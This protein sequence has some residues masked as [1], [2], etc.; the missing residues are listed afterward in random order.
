MKA[1][2]TLAATLF[3]AGLLMIAA[4]AGAGAADFET[5]IACGTSGNALPAHSCPQRRKIGVFFRSFNAK[6][7]FSFC[8]KFPSSQRICSE[9]T[10]AE[11]GHLYSHG[12][13]SGSGG[14]LRV[15][16]LV[17]GNPIGSKV[18]DVTVPG[19]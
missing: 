13:T 15:T 1:M 12:I 11:Q 6:V 8:V 3:A 16:W 5:Y 18:I 19:V 14:K 17:E 7:F 2:K 4:P 9:T 10:E